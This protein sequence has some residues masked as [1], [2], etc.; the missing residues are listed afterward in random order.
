MSIQTTSVNTVNT[1]VY[2][3]SGR[4]GL[5]ILSLCNH[6][7]NTV[8]VSL[9]VVPSGDTANTGNIMIKNLEIVAGDTFII[10]QGGEKLVLDD[11]DYIVA[12]ASDPAA[13]TAIASYMQ[14]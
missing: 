2:T 5:T 10:Y 7:A 8:T 6:S 13:V 3:S 4:T 12:I 1:T 9:Y 11:S 14:L